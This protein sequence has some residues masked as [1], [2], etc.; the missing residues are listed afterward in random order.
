M[1][2]GPDGVKPGLGATI[3][4]ALAKQLNAQIDIAASNPGTSVS[5]I[6]REPGLAAIA[7]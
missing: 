6:H 1:P 2:T 5:V 7:A 3:V 4:E